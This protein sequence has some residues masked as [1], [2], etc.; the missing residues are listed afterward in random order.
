MDVRKLNKTHVSNLQIVLI[1]IVRVQRSRN[2]LGVR[3]VQE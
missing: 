1:G 3:E 2:L